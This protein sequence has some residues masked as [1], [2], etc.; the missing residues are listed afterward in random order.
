MII[1]SQTR[2]EAIEKKEKEKAN[3]RNKKFETLQAKQLKKMLKQ[4][5]GCA[6]VQFFLCSFNTMQCIFN[7]VVLCVPVSTVTGYQLFKI[8]PLRDNV[9]SLSHILLLSVQSQQNQVSCQRYVFH[10]N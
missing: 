1:Y 4:P 10:S 7:E 8:L 3:K 5:N 9:E 6:D 2:I